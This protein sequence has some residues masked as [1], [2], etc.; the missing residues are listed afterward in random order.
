[1]KAGRRI[2]FDYGDVRIGVAISDLSGLLATPYGAIL[3]S[4]NTFNEIQELTSEYEPLYFVVGIPRHLS[5]NSSSKMENVEVFITRL[6]SLYSLP[7][8]RIDERLT[9]VSAAK[10]LQSAGKNAKQS[11]E[12]IDAAAAA[13]ILEMALMQER[14]RAVE[15][16][17]D[18]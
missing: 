2:A 16:G 3:N 4:E 8:V 10:N 15:E 11:K 7:I 9:T 13:T 14:S 5:G 18:E 6:K 12:L 1:M 17:D